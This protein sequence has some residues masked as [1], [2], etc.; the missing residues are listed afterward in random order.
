MKTLKNEPGL[1]IIYIPSIAIMTASPLARQLGR[2]ADETVISLLKT[3]T[4]KE[5]TA[6]SDNQT[7]KYLKL[8]T[9]QL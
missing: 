4:A 5:M 6:P 7:Y 3:A 9:F 2:W 1:F 8:K